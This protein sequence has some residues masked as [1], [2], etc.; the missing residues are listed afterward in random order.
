MT[1][2]TR[3][4]SRRSFWGALGHR[5][6]MRKFGYGDWV[7]VVVLFLLIVGTVN[8]FSSTFYMN[9]RSSA[10]IASDL[11]R[12]ALFL[13]LGAICGALV[14]RFNYQNLRKSMTL[15]IGITV[16]MLLLVQVAGLTVNGARRWIALGG[17]TFQ[18]SEVAKLVGIMCTASGLALRVE[19]GEPVR[20]WQSLGGAL[21]A[22]GKQ[23]WKRMKIFLAEWQPLLWP[24]V[25]GAL[26]FLQPDFGTVILVLGVPLLLYF[27]AGLPQLEIVGTLIAAAI[28]FVAGVIAAPYRMQRLVAWYDPFSYAR[29]LGYQVVQSIIAVGSGGFLGQGFG[30]GLSK[31][32]Y[33]PE[34]H[35]DFAYAVFAQEAGFW[36]AVF[37]PL[38]FLALLFTGFKIAGRARD[39]YSSYLVYGLVTLLV[40]QGLYNTAMTLGV[41][42]VTGVPLPFISYGGSAMVV[43]LISV[44]MI[45]G[46][47]RKTRELEEREAHWAKVRALSEGIAPNRRWQPPR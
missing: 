31:F 42:P 33:L 24:L 13:A 26:I 44:G 17:F 1:K 3:K 6:Q 11:F 2:R 32:A 23:Q 12:H 36:L 37:V 20:L 18:P 38:A 9:L 43:N 16:L 5:I 4:Q 15:W 45:L 28:L 27:L 29:D 22:A 10:G 39:H 30:Q 8:V 34:Q 14:Y 25:F 47:E 7:F 35:T 19:R 46:V 21:G 41:L 40:G